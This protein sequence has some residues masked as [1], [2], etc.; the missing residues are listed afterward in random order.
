M[1]GFS[2]VTQNENSKWYFGLNA[3]LDFMNSP[4]SPI[5]NSSLVSGLSSSS[6]ADTNGNLLFYTDGNKVWNSQNNLMANGTGLLGNPAI[7][8]SC[9]SAKKPGSSSLYYI[10]T[11]QGD[12]STIPGITVGGLKY[13]VVDLTLAAGQGSVV[14]K[15]SPLYNDSCYNQLTGTPHCN[16]R[17]IWIVV[18]QYYTN[19]FRAYLLTSSGVSSTPVI[20]VVN[21]KNPHY[22]GGQMRISPTG[23]KLGV[24]NFGGSVTNNLGY[25]SDMIELFDFDNSTGIVSNPLQLPGWIGAEACE[26]SADGTKFYVSRQ[27]AIG[28]GAYKLFQWDLCAGSHAAIKASRDSLYV[29]IGSFINMQLAPDGKIYLPQYMPGLM[30]V[31][32][33]PNAL[34]TTASNFSYLSVPISGTCSNGVPNLITKYQ[35][36]IGSFSFASAF[37]IDCHAISFTASPN[38][39]VSCMASHYSVTS[40]SWNFNDPVSGSANISFL[41]NPVH[42]YSSAGTFTPMQIFYYN[43]SSDTVRQVVTIPEPDILISLGQGTCNIPLPAT[44]TAIGGSGSYSFSW[45]P[46]SQTGTVA[47]LPPGTYTVIISDNG[48][49]CKAHTI[50]TVP[51]FPAPSFTIFP[52]SNTSVCLGSSISLSV[53]GTTGIYNWFPATGLNT[54][55]GLSV[56]A[57]P[58]SSQTY[59]VSTTLNFCTLSDSIKVIV[60]LL[61]GPTIKG[62]TLLCINDSLKLE[63]SGGV[64]YLW[65]SPDNM[66]YTGSMLK[67][68]GNASGNYTLFTTDLNGCKSFTTILIK[69]TDIPKGTLNGADK[70]CAPLR[71]NYTFLKSGLSKNIISS[72]MIGN[73]VFGDTFSYRFKEQGQYIITGTLYDTATTCSNRLLY[74][75]NV[76][77]KPEADFIYSPST[78]VENSEATSFINASSG[79]EQVKWEWFFNSNY[80]KKASGEQVF[81]NYPYAGI[82]PVALVVTNQWSC[83]DTIVRTVKIEPDF[84][85]YVPNAFTPDDNNRNE[86]FIPVVSGVKFYFLE[87]FDRWGNKVF[88]SHDALQGWDGTFKGQSCK[89]DTYIWKLEL[90]SLSGE[91][92]QMTG[93]IVLL[94]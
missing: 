70:G 30:S 94:R 57:N 45:T 44:V 59:T 86:L 76:Y 93:H 24:A 43:C 10:F 32:N 29:P 64:N 23:N 77:P 61:P 18:H 8:Q 34:G 47:A 79:K 35:R 73:Q 91:Q 5:L 54:T 72:W 51:S 40:I 69:L 33:N 74:Q 1:I 20:S 4:P 6:I 49:S 58:S 39:T 28:M 31:I 2:A 21:P 46:T 7:R 62:K 80:D 82:Y 68:T 81:Y 38:P 11:L 19:I 36:T 67:I 53:S 3:G 50:L 26:F 12:F 60:N 27:Y 17:D 25:I 9:L 55:N 41:Q 42:V 15:N 48:L 16:G 90:S 37:N 65:Q 22:W 88:V 92:K 78:L 13:S 87:I 89:E 56:I 52:G 66:Q 85:V 84:T 83:A 63:G 71:S 75:V 14:V